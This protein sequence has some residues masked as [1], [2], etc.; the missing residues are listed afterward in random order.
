MF[1]AS[2][3]CCLL[4]TANVILGP[5]LHIHEPASQHSTAIIFHNHNSYPV[6]VHR[7][8]ILLLL[9]LLMLVIPML[10]RFI[11][12]IL[13]KL[14]RWC[15]LFV[16]GPP[17]AAAAVAHH[18][19]MAMASPG[20]AG[21]STLTWPSPAPASLACT[22]S[23]AMLPRSCISATSGPWCSMSLF[24]R[25]INTCSSASSSSSNNNNKDGKER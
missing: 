12:I 6:D 11:H 23:G 22:A 13:F 8:L 25:G 16:S 14:R 2:Q 7:V 20:G 24:S 15:S 4:L 3:T 10:V 1:C 17:A 21:N 9:L 18:S 19:A 5:L